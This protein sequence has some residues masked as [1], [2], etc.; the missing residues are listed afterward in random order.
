MMQW[1]A[2][3]AL[4]AM[5]KRY[6]YDVSY[7]TFMLDRAPKAFFKFA[8][9][10][11]VA[12]HAGSAP[13]DAVY[14]AKLVAALSEDCG[15]CVQIVVNMARESGVPGMQIAAVLTRN[16]YAQNP[17][18]NLGVRFAEA[19]I[20]R[21][22][23]EDD[24]REEVRAAWGD[25]GVVDLALAIAIGRVFPMTKA[26]LGFAKACRR[27]SVDGAPVDVVKRAA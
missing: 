7:M 24:V 14:A 13:A 5:G 26:G 8:K 23:E 10:M 15:P 4:A 6:D 27:V 16:A 3:R 20:H 22:P 21:L 1:I 18:A 9:I 17:H 25:R 2:R 11:D 19:V 12:R